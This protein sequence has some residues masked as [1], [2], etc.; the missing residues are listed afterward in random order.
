MPVVCWCALVPLRQCVALA[1][2][3]S[4]IPLMASDYLTE[5]NDPGRTAWM[6]D[7]NVFTPANVKDI[8][9]LWKVKL[10]SQPREMHNI[11]SPLIAE[12]VTTARGPREIAIVAG[13]SDDLFGIDVASG[14]LLWKKRYESTFAPTDKTVYHTLC[15]GGQTAVPA[16]AQVAPGKYT[17][18]AIAW[19]GRL[20]QINAADGSD[21][22][23]PDKFLPPN[24]KPYALNVVN[25]VVYTATAQGCGGVPNAL[26]SYHLAT[27]KASTFQPAGG[28]MWGR[29]GAAVSPEGVV[30]MVTGDAIFSPLTKSLGNAIVGARLDDNQQLQLV[31]YFAP[32]NANWMRARDLDMNVTPMAFDY[33]G[34]KF[35]VGTSKEC[36]L[37]LLDRDALGG[38]D[39]RTTL[40][41]TP[42]LCNDDQA[43]DA[44]GVWGAMAAW[45]DSRGLQWVLVPFWGPVSRSFRAPIEYGRPKMGGVAAYKLEEATPGQWR[46]NPGWLSRD[47]DMAE[48]V[49]VANGVVFAYGSGED[50]TQ[51]LPDIAWN[52]P[53]GPWVG[54]GLNPYSERRIPSSRRA[55]LY[56]LDGQT[57]NELW[58]SGNQIT[59][60][61]HWSGLTVANG[62]AYLGTFDGTLYSFGIPAAARQ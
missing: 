5:G 57:G 44:K 4:W 7:E 10:D 54:G 21:V 53:G 50:T 18:Y 49:V 52:E 45:Q 26:Y 17:I 36:R 55:T 46:L 61:N 31:D 43:F 60:W 32:P 51:T 25:G 27:R 11:F 42:L 28:G 40:H 12:R 41:T 56:A 29:R 30:Y 62:R 38:E 2:I 19:D 1:V 22:A 24:G 33:R 20:H 6:K 39:H 37:W 34:R 59:S 3:G 16:M 23:P 47:M 14:E 48:E 58:S 8:K 35:L 15:L 13:I 9:L